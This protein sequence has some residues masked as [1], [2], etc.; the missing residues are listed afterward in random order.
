MSIKVIIIIVINNRF[1]ILEQI[2]GNLAA[3]NVLNVCLEMLHPRASRDYTKG[4]KRVV[5]NIYTSICLEIHWH[6]F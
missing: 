1:V 3:L 4:R 5:T 6:V 2:R